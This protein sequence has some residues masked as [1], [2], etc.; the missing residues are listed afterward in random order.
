MQS[1]LQSIA[2]TFFGEL[3]ADLQHYTFVFPNHRA[4]LF[5]RKYLSECV[6]KP[7]F[8]PRI[9]TIN[10]CFA[11]LT[12]LQVA[13]SLT[14]LLRLYEE[15]TQLRPDAEPLERFI[16]WGKMM[17]ADFSEIDNHLVEH[18]EALFSSV[19]D[20]HRIDEHFSY[21]TENQRNALARFWKEFHVS[22]ERHAHGTLHTRFLHTWD[23]LYP[24]YR[25]LRDSLLRDGIAYEGML[26]REVIEHWD[27]IAPARFSGQYVFIG[28]NALTASERELMLRLQA[29]GR[30]DFYFDYDGPFLSDPQNRASLFLEENRRLFH[31]RY[32]LPPCQ[33]VAPEINCISVPST[34][35]EVHEVH[36]IL[37]ENIPKDSVDLTHTAVVLP[38]EQLLIPLLSAFPEN[39]SKINVTM[40]YP[41]RAMSLYMPIA[42]PETV[43][44]PMPESAAAFLSQMRQYLVTLHTPENSEGIYQL[45]KVIDRL[46]AALDAYAR[47]TFSVADMQQLLKMLTLESTVAYAGEP[48]DGLQVMGVLETRALAF[49]NVIITGFNDELYPGRATGNSFIPYTLRRGFDMPTSERQ[50]AIFAY[51]FYRM[52]T[53]AKRVWLI[54]NS[55]VD[56]QHSGEV[57][58]YMQQL[59]LQYGIEV[60]KIVVTN[61]LVL[62]QNADIQPIA[63]DERLQNLHKLS[64][65]A[66]TTYLTCQKRFYY[67]YVLGLQEPQADE[68][69]LVS[70]RTLG[71]VLHAT[72]QHLYQP[73]V[74][75]NLTQQDIQTLLHQVQDDVFWYALPSLHDLQ[76]DQLAERVVRTYVIQTLNYDYTQTPFQ[77]LASE[78]Y[79]K[80]TLHLEGRELL[81][82]GV[83]DRVDSKAGQT[84]IVDYKA[85]ATDLLFTSMP[86][87][88]GVVDSAVDS[89][90]DALMIRSKCSKQILQTLMYCW[91]SEERYQNLVPHLYPVRKLGDL[92]T[93]TAACYKGTGMPLLWNEELK[94][95]FETELHSLLKEIYDMNIPFYPA[96]KQKTCENCAFAQLCQA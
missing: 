67:Q 56:G 6:D 65:T 5:F 54:T 7:L 51:N 3:G 93:P 2:R 68:R 75:K 15:Y 80:R 32:L 39:V 60:K 57:S 59:T 82:H 33:Y 87:V 69:V 92:T 74:G 29:M 77:Y 90:E 31:A 64:A 27:A 72:M 25:A 13:D 58:R 81:F 52:L 94:Q 83:V 46:H 55:S 66:L 43:L 19:R 11:E 16:Y 8:S 45:T 49:D 9:M 37:S 26:H 76:G 63:K 28:F 70:D 48:L 23:I 44:H 10:E 4:G 22:D 89:A 41:L 88:F 38:D 91:L 24:L 84:R 14:L 20:W 53:Y 17:L 71:I 30:A 42:Y 61:Q 85:G 47:I 1:K 86:E 40:G 34:V 21:L 78:L 50:D 62:S 73:F 18:V 12:D 95:D 79:L 36:R 96:P 35:G